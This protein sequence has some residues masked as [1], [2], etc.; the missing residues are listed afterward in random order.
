MKL[1]LDYIPHSFQKKFHD[2]DKK[3]RLELAGIRS[4]KTKSGLIEA[5][6]VSQRGWKTFKTPNYGCIVSPTYPMLRDIIFPL[7]FQDCPKEIIKK[8]SQFYMFV[9]FTNGSKILFRSAD[10]PTSLLGLDLHWFMI[11]EAALVSKQVY[12]IL[13]GRVAQKQGCGWITT[14]PQLFNN[15]IPEL[16]KENNPDF[17]YINFTSYDNPYFPKDEIEKL[18]SRYT[19]EYFESQ[20]IG[21]P[22]VKIKGQ[23]Y[24][25]FSPEKHVIDTK[26]AL[27]DH[28]I[29][30]IDFGFSNP[31]AIEVLGITEQGAKYIVDEFYLSDVLIGE[32]IEN[33]K[34][35]N[36]D[37]K[38]TELYCDPSSPEYILQIR[39]AGLNAQ[40]ANND[41]SEGI[42]LVTKNI[43][44][45][46][47]FV[48]P[49]C[50]N[51]IREFLT[52]CVKEGTDKPIK[53]DDHAVDALRYAIASIEKSSS[54]LVICR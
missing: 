32:L 27:I 40:A 42:S 10:K 29:A 28:Y 38:F 12:D 52:Y 31:S 48:D 33:L 1:Q 44:E 53:K 43:R 51:L 13:L 15:W 2:S 54:D 21:N 41:V 6:C 11:D 5:I 45:G 9:E 50:K 25:D 20:V 36:A 7:F 49:N 19:D 17:E 47:L 14:S 4:G 26:G 18:K 24:K 46:K 22:F 3:I 30:G 39:Q 35:L 34:A 8:F 23:I 16:I 37:Y